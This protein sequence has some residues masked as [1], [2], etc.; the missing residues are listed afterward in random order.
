MEKQTAVC[1]LRRSLQ[2]VLGLASG[3]EGNKLDEEQIKKAYRTKILQLQLNDPS[4]KAKFQRLKSFY[5]ILMD[6]KSRKQFDESFPRG[7]V[8]TK[9]QRNIL[10]GL[11]YLII[12][13]VEPNSTV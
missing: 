1:S 9:E 6:P 3:K 10:F 12:V 5:A 4:A 2:G 11:G 8:L 7:L 13:A